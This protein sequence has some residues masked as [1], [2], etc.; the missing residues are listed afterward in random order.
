MVSIRLSIQFRT[1]PVRSSRLWR[2]LQACYYNY[3]LVECFSHQPK[4]IIFYCSFS[5]RKSPQ[6]SRTLLI[7]LVV[8]NSAVVWTVPTR[9]PASKSSSPFNNP[10]APITISTIVTF[11]FHIFK[12]FSRKIDV[13]ILFFT[14]F[15][16]YS[17]V[18]QDSKV[19]YFAN[20]LVFFVDFLKFCFS[21]QD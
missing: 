10:L 7:I 18:S 20:Y 6:F 4:L 21:G 11:M 5:D 15:Q 2:R 19:H 9:L 13:L 3:L 16:F 17:T 14:F 8:L 12:K 1:L